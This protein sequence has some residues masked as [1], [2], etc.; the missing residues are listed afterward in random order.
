LHALDERDPRF[1]A[2]LDRGY[3]IAVGG[4]ISMTALVGLNARTARRT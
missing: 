2:I 4:D 1:A 3:A